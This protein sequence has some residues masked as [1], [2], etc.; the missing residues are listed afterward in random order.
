MSLYIVVYQGE[1]PLG[2]REGYGKIPPIISRC[3]PLAGV[4]V[5]V[6]VSL[7]CVEV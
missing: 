7:L 5:K 4:V 6:K 3:L 2:I 1:Y